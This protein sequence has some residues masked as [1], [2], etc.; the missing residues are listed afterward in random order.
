MKNANKVKN[1]VFEIV[2]IVEDKKAEEVRKESIFTT[3][4]ALKQILETEGMLD[5]FKS[6]MG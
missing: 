1:E 5:F 2:A 4:K 6:A 3:I